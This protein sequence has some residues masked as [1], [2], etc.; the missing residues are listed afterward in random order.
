MQGR[1][2]FIIAATV[3]LTAL[4][5][6]AG[7][8]ALHLRADDRQDRYEILIEL[9]ADANRI[10]ALE[11]EANAQRRVPLAVQAEITQLLTHMNTQF[12][13]LVARDTEGVAD[14]RDVFVGYRPQIA[15]EFALMRAR[16]FERANA[17]DLQIDFE[18]IRHGLRSAA[19]RNHAVAEDWNRLSWIGTVA[20]ML[21]AV[22][23]LT[24]LL[25]LL[26]RAGRRRV[27]DEQL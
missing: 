10:D 23:A 27:R 1:R 18:R 3:A 15:E 7:I 8:A 17:L 22:I 20:V 2:T 16:D 26:D 14:V 24:P 19:D 25:A 5:A 4:V 9:S 12:S 13:G 6:S 21:L 11:S